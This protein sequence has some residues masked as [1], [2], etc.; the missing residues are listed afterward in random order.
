MLSSL[1]GAEA[2]GQE[3]KKGEKMDLK[4]LQFFNGCFLGESSQTF[5]TEV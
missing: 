3:T 2:G 5:Y 4:D 1:Q